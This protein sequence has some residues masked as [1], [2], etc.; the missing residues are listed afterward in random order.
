LK[1]RF[2]SKYDI[3]NENEESYQTR[4]HEFGVSTYGWGQLNFK[5]NKLTL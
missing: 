3:R 1:Y 4:Y 5:I 2:N